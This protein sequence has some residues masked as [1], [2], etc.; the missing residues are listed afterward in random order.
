MI[1]VRRV[2][3]FVLPALACLVPAPAG[4]QEPR[5]RIAVTPAA[6]T[7]GSDAEVGVGGSVGY[8][9]SDHLWFEGDVTWVGAAAGGFRN[10]EFTFDGR[11]ATNPVMRD[12]MTRQGT[13]GSG[14][15]GGTTFPNVPTMIGTSAARAAIDGQ[16]FIGTLGVRY[17]FASQAARFRPYVAGGLGINT[18]TQEFSIAATNVT[19][20]VDDE[21]SHTGYAFSGGAGASVRLVSIVWFDAEA[22][23]FRLSQERNVMRLGGGLSVRF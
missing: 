20:R 11:R 5:I 16:T 8:R 15:F 4:A 6:V 22:K 3:L 23:Y 13:F 7:V 17:E 1:R 14:R 12:L 10:G 21:V 2:A 9:F 19:P 18:T